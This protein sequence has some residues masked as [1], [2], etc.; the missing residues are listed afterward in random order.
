M[1]DHILSL[2]KDVHSVEEHL[3]LHKS[4]PKNNV[5]LFQKKMD[6]DIFLARLR[7]ILVSRISWQATDIIFLVHRD[8]LRFNTSDQ[9]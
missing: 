6:I 4:R 5:T 8:T 9:K 2:Q 3:S 1:K 7:Y